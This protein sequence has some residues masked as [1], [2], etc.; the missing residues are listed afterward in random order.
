MLLQIALIAI[1]FIVAI[2]CDSITLFSKV[3]KTLFLIFLLL[4]GFS[5]KAL[6]S[7]ILFSNR[8]SE[9]AVIGKKYIVSSMAGMPLNQENFHLYDLESKKLILDDKL[10]LKV[11]STKLKTRDTVTVSFKVGVWSIAFL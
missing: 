4:F 9:K 7:L 6:V 10:L 11:Y 3:T 8:Q 2:F 5:Q 1:G